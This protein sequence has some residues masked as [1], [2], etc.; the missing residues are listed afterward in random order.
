[1]DLD[2]QLKASLGD[3]YE[4]ERELGAG[5]MARVLDYARNIDGGSGRWG[6]A[7]Y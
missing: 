4:L 1:M 3:N 7:F 2:T 6:V 5:G